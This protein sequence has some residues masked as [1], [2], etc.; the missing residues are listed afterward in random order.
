MLAEGH[1]LAQ[2]V[3]ACGFGSPA[4]ITD[5]AREDEEF[6]ARYA[7]AMEQ[8]T[9]HMAEEILSIA[10]D[11][12]NDW[13]EREGFVVPNYEHIQ[14]SKLRVDA[15]RWLMSKM[16]PKKYGD[17]LSHE[18]GGPDGGPI[19]LATGVIRDGEED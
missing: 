12:N 14:R 5:W 9:D 2:C 4:K 10:D 18:H 6:A 3:R 15:R 1:T 13:M 11:G 8:R 16:L 17:R 19:I 7:R